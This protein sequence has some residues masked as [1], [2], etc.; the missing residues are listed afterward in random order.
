MAEPLMEEEQED[1]R[2]GSSSTG[3]LAPRWA[4][5]PQEAMLVA[6][7]FWH[8]GQGIWVVRWGPLTSSKAQGKAPAVEPLPPEMDKELAQRLQQE[9][10]AV[11][12]AW[13]GWDAATLEVVKEA[14]GLLMLGQLE[15]LGGAS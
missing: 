9:E 10:V 5:A 4:S 2:R 11:E 1:W 12:E 8:P 7:G 15:G 3:G 14:A 6:L 13:L